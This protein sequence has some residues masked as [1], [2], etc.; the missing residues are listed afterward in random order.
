MTPAA[1]VQAAI[2]VLDL[3]ISAARDNG[4]P[5]DRL[6]TDWFRTR[7]FAGSGD[8][9]AVRDLVYSAVRA[10]GEIPATARAAMLRL[11]QG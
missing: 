8:R 1:R 7:R 3:I 5:A 4:P 2:E 9:R 11:A 6:I 10:C